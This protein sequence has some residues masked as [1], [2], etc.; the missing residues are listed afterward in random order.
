MWALLR[1]SLSQQLDYWLQLCY[2]TDVA[3]AAERMDNVMWQALQVAAGSNI[4]RENDSEWNCVL[5]ILIET[6][7]GRSFQQILVAQPVKRGGFGIR[8]QADVSLTGFVG[9]LEQTIPPFV[10][11]RGICQHGYSLC[12]AHSRVC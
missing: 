10:S 9:A 1:S 5:G 6:L 2:P 7:R 12:Q 3:F 11:D 4:P 8:A